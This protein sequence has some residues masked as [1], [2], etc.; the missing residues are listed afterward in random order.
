M[1]TSLSFYSFD[2]LECIQF[3]AIQL[4]DQPADSGWWGAM[5]MCKHLFARNRIEH[6]ENCLRCLTMLS[7]LE[8]GAY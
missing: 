6:F 8:E 1:E 5:K 7:L 3:A 4:R 2:L